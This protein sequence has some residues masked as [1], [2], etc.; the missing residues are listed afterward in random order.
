MKIFFKKVSLFVTM[1]ATPIIIFLLVCLFIYFYEPKPP[2]NYTISK[3]YNIDSFPKRAIIIKKTYSITN[4]ELIFN[5]VFKILNKMTKFNFFSP[6]EYSKFEYANSLNIHYV[7]FK[8]GF[9]HPPFDG[10]GNIM[11]HA[12]TPP[13]IRICFDLSEKW[14]EKKL[15]TTFFHELLHFLGLQHS[16]IKESI[17][18]YSYSYKFAPTHNDILNLKRIYPFICNK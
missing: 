6:I 13:G 15:H 14:T 9:N 7:M 17:M 11:A 12:E 2:E 8:H 10:A 16:K 4:D 3:Y 5:N 1:I 18:Y